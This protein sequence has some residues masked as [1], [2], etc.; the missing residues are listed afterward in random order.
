MRLHKPI[1]I[2]LLLWP[3]LWAL[4]IANKGLADWHLIIIFLL[5]VIVMRSAGCV[6]NDIADRKFDGRVERTKNRPLVTGE[7]KLK[8]AIA[9]FVILCLIGFWLVLQL[10]A[11]TLML[12]FVG[13][14]L[15]IAYP[16]AKRVT[17]FPQ[18]LLG[19]AF[20]WSVPMVFAASTSTVPLEAWL[21]YSIAI[22]WPIAYDSIYALMDREDDLQIGVKS[23]VIF[24]GRFD[25]L[26]IFLLQALVIISLLILGILL[27]NGT[28]YYFA[29][30]ASTLLICYQYCMVSRKNYYQ[31]FS[32]NNWLGLIIFLGIALNYY[33]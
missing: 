18:V 13:L 24:F 21:I 11:L 1:G 5:G 28:C 31:A 27:K 30:F 25:I 12:S 17:H 23:T 4:L 8:E 7:V 32:N 9:V 33:S 15:A 29:V 20:G 16:F 19:A 3:T 6:I 10:N 26:W 2:L 14:L 22:L